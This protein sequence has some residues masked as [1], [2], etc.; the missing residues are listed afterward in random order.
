MVEHQAQEAV[1]MGTPTKPKCKRI[2]VARCL[3]KKNMVIQERRRRR[4]IRK[5]RSHWQSL[6]VQFSVLVRTMRTRGIKTGIEQRGCLGAKGKG[7]TMI[8]TAAVLGMAMIVFRIIPASKE[9]AAT[10]SQT[11]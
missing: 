8:A 6:V 10:N 9:A 11:T 2:T 5:L 4:K 7:L 3:R 1:N